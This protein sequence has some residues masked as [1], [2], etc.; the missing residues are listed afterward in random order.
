LDFRKLNILRGFT[1]LELLIVLM[2]MGL[3][4]TIL[5]TNSSFLDRYTKDKIESYGEF[6]QFLSEES[7][8]TKKTIAW[9]VGNQTQ[10]IF[11]FK[12]SRSYPYHIDADYFPVIKNSTLFTNS[13][14]RSYVWEE[15]IDAPFLIFYPSG[16]SSGGTIEAIEA[17]QKTILSIDSFGLMSVKIKHHA[18]K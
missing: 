17:D 18:N 7:S 12:N 11:Y 5:I 9:H 2:L 4:S 1:L 13:I 16:Q 10:S 3:M 6:I 8:L 15:E 14:G